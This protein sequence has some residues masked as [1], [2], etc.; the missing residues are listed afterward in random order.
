MTASLT[1]GV[2]ISAPIVLFSA[3]ISLMKIDTFTDADA[4]TLDRFW[5][6][7]PKRNIS[8]PGGTASSDATVFERQNN[9]FPITIAAWGSS[10]NSGVCATISGFPICDWCVRFFFGC[11][12]RLYRRMAGARSPFVDTS[13]L[14][15]LHI[16]PYDFND[17]AKYPS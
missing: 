11:L 2:R 8:L 1:M 5:S 13:A 10:G 12:S 15:L 14:S 3:L 9:R 6:G 4:A 17:F 16:P 7:I